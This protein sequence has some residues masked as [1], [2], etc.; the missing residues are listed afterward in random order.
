MTATLA[1]NIHKDITQCIGGTPL[2]LLNRIA[3][4]PRPRSRPSSRTSIHSGV[5]RIASAGR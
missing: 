3:G 5:S 1:P 2:V 4:M